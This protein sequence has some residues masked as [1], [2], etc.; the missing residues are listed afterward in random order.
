MSE[1]VYFKVAFLSDIVLNASSN[2]EGKVEILDFITGS[3]FLGMV[4]KEYDKYKNPFDIF[5]SGKVRFSEAIPLFGE[6]LSY[7]APFSFFYPKNDKSLEEVYNNHFLDYSKQEIKDKQPK[8]LR[9]GYITSD[10]EYF[11]LDFNYEQKSAFDK[12]LR[13]SKKSSMFGYKAL[14][15]GSIWSF[16]IEFDKDINEE[17][18]KRVLSLLEGEKNLGKSKQSQ[19]GRV[20]IE[21]ISDELE[22]NIEEEVKEDSITYM[23][24]NSSLALVDENGFPSYIPNEKNLIH[25]KDKKNL[26]LKDTKV[27]LEKSQ[28]RTKEITPFN[29]I[30]KTND[31][32]RLIIEKGSVIALENVSKEDEKILKKGIGTYLSE[33][34]GQ[35]LLNPKFLLLGKNNE[36]FDL[37]KQDYIYEDT[38]ENLGKKDEVL[39]SFLLKK[40]ENKEKEQTIAQEVQEFIKNNKNKFKKVKKSQWGQIRA[41]LQVN[42]KNY[43]DEIENFITHGVSEK[44]WKEGE[45]IIKDIVKTKSFEFLKLLSIQMPKQGDDK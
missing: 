28:I 6:K 2:T 21:K 22:E 1:K 5:H 10:L 27:I 14:K 31:S 8:Q 40:V 32:S 16:F 15:K 3:A 20:R 26:K 18:K 41:I 39:L 36:S 43:A 4:A 19:Y 45:D 24:V 11:E 42:N 9:K 44:Q 35:V 29:G 23:Y 12:N 34:Y 37:K 17:D 25:I 38:V 13:K 7:K 30:R 33:G